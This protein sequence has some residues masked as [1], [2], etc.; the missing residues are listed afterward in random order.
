MNAPPSGTSTAQPPAPEQ[1]T[2]GEQGRSRADGAAAPALELRQARREEIDEDVVV[3]ERSA[4]NRLR[5]RTVRLRQSACFFTLGQ[6]V[7]LHQSAGGLLAGVKLTAE[8]TGATWLVAGLLQARQVVAIA[9][10]AGKVEGP[11]RCLFDTRGAFAF[12][13]GLAL[14]SALLRLFVRQR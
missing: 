2:L 12:G 3:A 10:I 1:A 8:Q 7:R 13:A 14:M 11:V 9:V 4:I 6:D 5:A